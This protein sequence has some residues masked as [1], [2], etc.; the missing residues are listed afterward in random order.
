[1]GKGRKKQGEG[2]TVNDGHKGG[3]KDSPDDV[4]FPLEGLDADRGDFDNHDYTVVSIA[5]KKNQCDVQL[6]AQFE[7]VPNAAPLVRILR[8]L[9]SVGYSQGTPCMPI[10]KKI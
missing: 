7:A 6:K 1:M 8:E 10:P 3:V 2:L 5:Q 9:I 4:E